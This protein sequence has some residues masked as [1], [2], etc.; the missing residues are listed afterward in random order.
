LIPAISCMLLQQQ[1][2]FVRSIDQIHVMHQ[3]LNITCMYSDCNKLRDFLSY[4][5]AIFLNF[6]EYFSHL[7]I[8]QCHA[9]SHGIC[10]WNSAIWQLCTTPSLITLNLASRLTP[11]LIPSVGL[12]K[13]NRTTMTSSSSSRHSTQAEP[14][15]YQDDIWENIFQISS[16]PIA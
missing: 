15:E 9:V 8:G 10:N 2:L 3:T 5:A 14:G 7:G 4:R 11:T 12:Q 13:C 1:Q 16:I 6:R